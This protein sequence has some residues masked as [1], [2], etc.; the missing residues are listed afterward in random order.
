MLL[1]STSS[2]QKEAAQAQRICR[3][4][5]YFISGSLTNRAMHKKRSV[6]Y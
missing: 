6:A 2:M 3:S 4:V 5:A 1:I